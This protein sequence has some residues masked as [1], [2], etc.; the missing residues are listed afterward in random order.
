MRKIRLLNFS[1]AFFITFALIEGVA[2][3]IENNAA[4]QNTSVTSF[5]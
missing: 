1:T 2:F 4:D 5:I 3:G